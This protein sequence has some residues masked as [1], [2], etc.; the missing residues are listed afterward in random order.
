MTQRAV[1]AWLFNVEWVAPTNHSS[2]HK[3]RLNDRSYD[4][5]IWTDLN[6]VR[7]VIIHAFDRQTQT[8][9]FLVASPRWHSMQRGK[10]CNY[11]EQC[12]NVKIY[13]SLIHHIGSK[14]LY[15]TI[16]T[17]FQKKTSTHII[18]YK[19]RNSCPILVIFDIKIPHII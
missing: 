10:N 6:F 12:N 11:I 2:S 16:Y 18:G 7:F 8:D 13:S 15:N 4:I 14:Q 9:S 3:T 17:V 5:K 19:L 1:F